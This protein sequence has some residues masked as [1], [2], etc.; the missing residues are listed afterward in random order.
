VVK[1]GAGL[2]DCNALPPGKPR[3]LRSVGRAVGAIPR[4]FTHL[5][6]DPSTLAARQSAPFAGSRKCRQPWPTQA[7]WSRS[8]DR[9]PT[10]A[11]A[12]EGA[13]A[14]VTRRGARGS[15]G[16]PSAHP[17]PTCP[18]LD[19]A[20]PML[21]GEA[22]PR[23]PSL[24]RGGRHPAHRPRFERGDAPARGTRRGSTEGMAPWRHL[25]AGMKPG[26]ARLRTLAVSASAPDRQNS[27][28]VETP[29]AGE[30][31]GALPGVEQVVQITWAARTAQA[32][33]GRDRQR[34]CGGR[35]T[36]QEFLHAA[37]S[38]VRREG[39]RGPRREPRAEEDSRL[40]GVPARRTCVAEIG[41][42][43]ASPEKP[44]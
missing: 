31:G 23:A 5:R 10:C 41:S 4:S 24:Y 9:R 13:R 25:T 42:A 6:G 8:P 18:S 32:V 20:R 17:G 14:S 26:R 3:D 2:S 44:V 43:V 27:Q 16:A 34:S 36:P 35:P 19:H 29:M 28:R 1:K 30:R 21:P 12:T 40:A 7:R 33:S 39:K 22:I 11:S 37:R 15:P 38:R